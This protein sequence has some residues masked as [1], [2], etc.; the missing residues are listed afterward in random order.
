MLYCF[1]L[2]LVDACG[3]QLLLPC[4]EQCTF[5]VQSMMNTIPRLSFH[6][7][8]EITVEGAAVIRDKAAHCQQVCLHMPVVNN[9]A[10]ST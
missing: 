2:Q 8:V 5:A 1:N 3:P 10:P 9:R 7:D 4:P 6:R